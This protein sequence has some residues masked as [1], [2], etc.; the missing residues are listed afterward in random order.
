[1]CIRD[2]SI[3][4]LGSFVQSPWKKSFVPLLGETRSLDD[5]DKRIEAVKKE[6]GGQQQRASAATHAVTQQKLGLE[7]ELKSLRAKVAESAEREVE[8]RRIAKEALVAA[9]TE[10]IATRL[11]T[12]RA[13][14]PAL[15]QLEFANVLKT[16][17]TRGSMSIDT[18]RRISDTVG[19]LPIEV[20]TGPAPGPA[21][22]GSTAPGGARSAA[23]ES[24]PAALL[25]VDDQHLVQLLLAPRVLVARLEEREQIRHDLSVGRWARSGEAS[26]RGFGVWVGGGAGLLG[27][28]G[29]RAVSYTHL[30]LPTSDLV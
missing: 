1:M 11:E 15:W 27:A 25:H 13:L 10:A 23:S 18:A 5:I 12:D 8:A 30:T 4:D 9:Y 16:A 14:V 29:G 26:V 24:T 6:L 21:V 3:K 19:D 7:A 2:R 28:S 17:C 20:D 22:P